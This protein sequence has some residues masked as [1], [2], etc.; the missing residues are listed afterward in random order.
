MGAVSVIFAGKLCFAGLRRAFLPL[1]IEKGEKIM[2]SIFGAVLAGALAVWMLLGAAGLPVGA[3]VLGGRERI[4]AGWKRAVAAGAAVLALFAG[5]CVLC[6]GGEIPGALP[7]GLARGFCLFFAVCL[8]VGV[9]FPLCSKSAKERMVMT[10]AC[11]LAAAC[12]WITAL[13]G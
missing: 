8:T 3:F 6:A 13:G 5:F 11:V 2:A 9:L 12:F 10:P 1:R 7:A 4:L